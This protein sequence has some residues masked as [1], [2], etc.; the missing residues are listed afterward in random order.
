[1]RWREGDKYVFHRERVVAATEAEAVKYFQ[2]LDEN[3]AERGTAL[4][5]D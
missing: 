4:G 5:E 3:H 1:M 2:E